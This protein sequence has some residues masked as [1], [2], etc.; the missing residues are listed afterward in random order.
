MT[1]VEAMTVTGA[2]FSQ[3][4]QRY[5]ILKVRVRSAHFYYAYKL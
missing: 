3:F 1:H 2:R 5:K 4:I